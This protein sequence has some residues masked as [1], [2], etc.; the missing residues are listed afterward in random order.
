MRKLLIIPLLFFIFLF[1]FCS[2]PKLT[3][4]INIE[5]AKLNPNAKPFFADLLPTD[6]LVISNKPYGITLTNIPGYITFP[7]TAFG[8][9]YYL[10]QIVFHTPS[11]HTVKGKHFPA[12]MQFIC[13]DTAGNIAVLSVFINYGN[14]NS[15]IQTV[16]SHLPKKNSSVKLN[17]QFQV[18]LLL[19]LSVNYW[20]YVGS[21]T[22][23]PYKQNVRW[24]ILRKPI[25]ASKQQ[26]QKLQQ[27][28]GKNIQPLQPLG[29]RQ[30]T[31]F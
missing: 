23:P 6:S 3:S 21:L 26:I 18:N 8:H 25:S 22:I 13:I 31:M 29:N 16:V 30:I 27:A 15:A 4:P 28:E 1:Q 11:E 10:S 5:N 7:D 14:P 17:S 2:K 12:E 24:F 19:P 20:Y 9:N